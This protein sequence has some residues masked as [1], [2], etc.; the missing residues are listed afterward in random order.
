VSDLLQP[1]LPTQISRRALEPLLAALGV[2][3]LDLTGLQ[4]DADRQVLTVTRERRNPIGTVQMDAVRQRTV[5]AYEVVI[6]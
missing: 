6:A 1:P 5:E 2:D 3:L 4:Y